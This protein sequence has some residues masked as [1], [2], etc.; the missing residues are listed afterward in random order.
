MQRYIFLV[1]ASWEIMLD[2]CKMQ[3]SMRLTVKLAGGSC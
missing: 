1:S 3:E 2:V